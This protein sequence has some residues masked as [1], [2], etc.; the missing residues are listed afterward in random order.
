[1]RGLLAALLAAAIATP[2]ALA[3]EKARET[4][5]LRQAERADLVVE[6][7]LQ[8]AVGASRAAFEGARA[9]PAA[10]YA[11]GPRAPRAA[12][13]AVGSP[14]RYSAEKGKVPAPPKEAADEGGGG[15][16]G[17]KAPVIGAALGIL[18]GAAIGFALGGP[19]GAI[20]GICVGVLAGALAGKLLGRKKK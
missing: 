17:G 4:P 10:V 16:D 5:V 20:A 15:D 18:A 12:A 11:G 13:P 1:M 9:A 3:L 14:R 8:D 6:G 19:I 2:P 7:P